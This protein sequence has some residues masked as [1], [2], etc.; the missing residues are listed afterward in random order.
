[1]PLLSAHACAIPAIM[2]TRTIRDAR[3]RLV[4]ILVAPLMTCS[5]RI[6]V[7]ALLIAFAIPSMAL[8]AAFFMVNQIQN[9]SPW[10][11][12]YREIWNYGEASSGYVETRFRFF[13]PMAKPPTP[14]SFGGMK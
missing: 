4:T 12:G 3:D 1:M 13:Q 5:A 14:L 11:V 8:A 6:P 7:Y 9:G 2:A 10:N